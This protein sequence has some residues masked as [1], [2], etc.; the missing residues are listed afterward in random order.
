MAWDGA[1]PERSGCI[2]SD[3]A[4]VGV[5]SE[6]Q[7]LVSLSLLFVFSFPQQL[8]MVVVVVAL[9]RSWSH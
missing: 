5:L 9:V 3:P 2:I 4:L 8:E 6:V 1:A 7:G